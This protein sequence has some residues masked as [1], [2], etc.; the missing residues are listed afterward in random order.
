MAA[1]LLGL[2]RHRVLSAIASSVA[3]VSGRDTRDELVEAA[4]VMPV[5]SDSLSL[6][7]AVTHLL[8]YASVPIRLRNFY[9]APE[10]RN[11]VMSRS[12]FD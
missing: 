1:R 4:A 9:G 2:S 6:D 5:E 11:S 3:S 8:H 12:R 10:I 7:A